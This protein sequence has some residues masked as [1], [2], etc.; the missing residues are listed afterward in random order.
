VAEGARETD[1]GTRILENAFPDAGTS[2]I[3]TVVGIGPRLVARLIDTVLIGILS[4]IAATAAGLIGEF[5]GMYSSN[6]SGWGAL[7]TVVAGLAFS[8]AYYVYGWAKEGQTLGDTL[9]GVKIVTEQ[10]SPPSVGQAILRYF[11]YLI[12][13]LALSLGFIWIAIDSRRQGWHDKM[14]KTYVIPTDQYFSGLDR[15]TF[16]PADGGAAPVWI[17]A[18]VIL[19]LLAPSALGAG[20]WT[21]GPFVEMAVR[22]LRGG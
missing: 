19:A 10:G 5:I 3:V 20:L 4:F 1:P 16:R 14:A 11:G 7:F 9:L 22:Q 21:L 18:W 13:A 17:G 8:F 2:K 12:S 6:F 15:V